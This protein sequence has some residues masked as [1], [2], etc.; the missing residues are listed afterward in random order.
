MTEYI[1]VAE[2]ENDEA[3]EIP[4]EEDGTLLLSTLSA[5]FPGACGL[6]FR[7]PATGNFRGVRLNDGK[8]HA[9]DSAWGNDTFI[10]VF[11][12]SS[13]GSEIQETDNQIH[14]IT[15]LCSKNILGKERMSFRQCIVNPQGYVFRVY[16]H[17]GPKL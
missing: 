17:I 1:S 6:K 11:P 4:S 5:Q 7:N 14:H 15:S 9:P 13:V 8:L 3:V 16:G 10:V 2:L 12:R